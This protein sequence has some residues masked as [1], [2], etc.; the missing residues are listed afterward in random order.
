MFRITEDT[1]SESLMQC[2]VKMISMILSCPLTWTTSLF[3]NFNC[4]YEL[5]ISASVGL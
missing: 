5:Y 3:Y 4:I 1:S 2:L